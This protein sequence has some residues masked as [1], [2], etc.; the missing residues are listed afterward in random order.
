[1]ET[2][3]LTC[4]GNWLGGIVEQA[5]SLLNY[6]AV[7][8]F[9]PFESLCKSSNRA[10]ISWDRNWLNSVRP[11]NFPILESRPAV[12]G[13]DSVHA[14]E[15]SP[16]TLSLSDGWE[17][18][19]KNQGELDKQLL[20]LRRSFKLVLIAGARPAYPSFGRKGSASSSAGPPAAAP[21]TRFAWSATESPRSH[22][23]PAQCAAAACLPA[24]LLSS[25]RQIRK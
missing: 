23:A 20:W 16:A 13:L 21:S 14:G 1:M 25:S 3:R 11:P 8:L 4:S 15:A 17:G 6:R 22:L 9:P 12:L 7:D 19:S 18:R 10:S 2:H 5:I 24:R